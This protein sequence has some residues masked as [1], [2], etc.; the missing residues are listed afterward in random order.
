MADNFTVGAA[1]FHR[2]IIT[3][4]V[5]FVLGGCTLE[6]D[7]ARCEVEAIRLYPNDPRAESASRYAVA[8]MKAKGYDFDGTCSVYRPGHAT[9]PICYT[10]SGLMARYLKRD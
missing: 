3:M 6:E 4:M 1:I 8:C 9:S 7:L 10:S 5:A 2:A